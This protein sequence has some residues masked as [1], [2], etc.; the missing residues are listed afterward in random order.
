MNRGSIS[1]MNIARVSKLNPNANSER[2]KP[3][4][5]T[6]QKKSQSIFDRDLKNP[7]KNNEF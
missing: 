5:S 6:F 2:S 1:A 7:T 3:V 4:T